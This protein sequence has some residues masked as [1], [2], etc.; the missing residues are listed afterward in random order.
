MLNRCAQ[1]PRERLPFDSYFANYC[2]AQVGSNPS[3]TT[4]PNCCEAGPAQLDGH[5]PV[6]LDDAQNISFD[7]NHFHYC[8]LDEINGGLMDRYISSSVP[9]C[10][11]AN[12]FAYADAA[13]MST[14]WDYAR[15]YAL[16]DRYFQPSAGASSQ[17]DMYFATTQIVF[18]D[19]NYAPNSVGSACFA[20]GRKATFTG[21][22]LGDILG[23]CGVSWAFYAEGYQ[24][25]LDNPFVCTAYPEGYD[26]SDN[27]FQYYSQFRDNL[28]YQ[29]DYQQF[30][31]DIAAGTL[32]SLSFIKALGS[33][34]EHPESTIS[35]GV[36][37]VSGVVDTI[38]NSPTYQNNTLVLVVPDESGGYY[39]HVSPPPTSTVDNQ[40][41]GARVPLWAI[42]YFAKTNI[43]SHVVMEHSS[44]VR[45]I[46]W[47]F[48]G[49]PPGQLGARDGTVNGIGSLIDPV[50]AGI[51]VP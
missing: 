41:Y 16:A 4:G 8:E 50:K 48:L 9:Y 2:K 33:R 39:D 36:Q 12:N 31:A 38:L 15:N 13:T 23:S 43:V 11:N 28:T 24:Y 22:T 14:Y 35:E 10:G 30:S 44:I 7:P 3:C 40:P 26:P 27:P 6:V 29:K 18:L 32:P 47:N 1:H 45:F 42:G 17:N 19:N 5:S 46:E 51:V 34:S 20:P 25:A 37:F 21:T 49:G